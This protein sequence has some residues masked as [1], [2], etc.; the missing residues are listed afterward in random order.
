MTGALVRRLATVAVLSALAGACAQPREGKVVGSTLEILGPTVAFAEQLRGRELPS[1][2]IVG[3]DPPPGSL[4]VDAVERLPALRV[5]PG[6]K[7][8]TLL[9]RTRASLLAAPYLSWHW[10]VAET[11]RATHPVRIVVGFANVRNPGERRSA[12]FPGSDSLPDEVD[13]LAMIVWTD[14]GLRRGTARML[15][16]GDAEAEAFE[17]AVRGGGENAGKWW[18]DSVDLSRLFAGAWPDV[19]LAGIEVR[20]VGIAA[21]PHTGGGTMHFANIRLSR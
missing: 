6:R 15:T 4:S 17:Y 7:A 20:L 19:E 16:R 18:V 3:G 10:H 13:R 21:A 9:R 2:W 5:I 12:W 1:D 8:Y 14:S 11:D